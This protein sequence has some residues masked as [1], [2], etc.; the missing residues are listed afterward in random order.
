MNLLPVYYD[1]YIKTK[2]RTYSDNAY[3]HFCGLN[4]KD[5]VECESFT[6]IFVDSLLVRVKKILLFLE[7]WMTKKP[8]PR[9]P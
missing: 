1:R 4:V 3:S 7:M 6:V 5:G 2:I 8:L 9:Q